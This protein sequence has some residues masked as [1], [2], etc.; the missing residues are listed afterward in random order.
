[1]KDITIDLL[2]HGDPS[3][4]RKLLGLTKGDLI[5]IVLTLV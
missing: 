2:R 5:H 4:G 1:M 3:T